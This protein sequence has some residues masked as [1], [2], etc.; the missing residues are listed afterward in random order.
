MIKIEKKDGVLHLILLSVYL[1]ITH[2]SIPF[3]WIHEN[4]SNL[5][6]LQKYELIISIQMDIACNN[7]SFH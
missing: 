1:D 5:L 4:I 3:G 6:V 7:F 2:Q